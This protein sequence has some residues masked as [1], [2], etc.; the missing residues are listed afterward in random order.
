MVT[1]GSQEKDVMATLEL[2]FFKLVKLILGRSMVFVELPQDFA[3]GDNLNQST[4]FKC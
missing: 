2:N 3:E 1:I 4:N